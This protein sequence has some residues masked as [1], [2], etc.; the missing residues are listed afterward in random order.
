MCSG[1]RIRKNNLIPKKLFRISFFLFYC[2]SCC[3]TRY[4]ASQSSVQYYWNTKNESDYLCCELLP[5]YQCRLLIT[6]ENILD[7]DQARK[8]VGPDLDA[9]CLRSNKI[10]KN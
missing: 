3:F 6:F 4:D 7:P 2:C 5:T 8:N 9:N 10:S 1:G